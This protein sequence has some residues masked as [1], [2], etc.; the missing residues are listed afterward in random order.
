[1]NYS[2]LSPEYPKM[3]AL[4][5]LKAFQ[6]PLIN[7]MMSYSDFKKSRKNESMQDIEPKLAQNTELKPSQN[8][9]KNL[10]KNKSKNVK[11]HSA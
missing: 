6:S 4:K 9:P 7:S 10:V 3:R 2:F 5:K 1:M 8:T 11:E